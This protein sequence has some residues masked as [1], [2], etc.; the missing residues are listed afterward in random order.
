MSREVASKEAVRAA[1]EQLL[2]KG[3]S[4]TQQSVQAITGGSMSRVNQFLKEL[5]EE[6][7]GHGVSPLERLARLVMALHAEL[8]QQANDTVAKG[9]ADSQKVVVAA[10][11]NL[12]VVQQNF[13]ILQQDLA[14][15]H[16]KISAQSA[17]YTKTVGLLNRANE[18]LAAQ[19]VRL[20][21]TEQARS[22]LQ[23]RATTLEES[24]AKNQDALMAYQ[25]HVADDREKSTNAFESALEVLKTEIREAYNQVS[26][27]ELSLQ[28]ATTQNLALSRDV[29]RFTGEVGE[30]GKRIQELED[31]IKT[32][33][34]KS[35]SLRE[36]ETSLKVATASAEGKIH[37]LTQQLEDCSAVHNSSLNQKSQR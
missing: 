25:R 29:E 26:I 22:L 32:E 36:S 28:E 14:S 30:L 3:I 37:L 12:K 27:S 16:K 34:A 35:D 11:E 1:R 5:D 9:A 33:R 4:P 21:T 7:H 15:A 10:K 23:S 20:R 31:E 19:A 18:E 13:A 6:R 2:N 8:Q 24:L 17:D